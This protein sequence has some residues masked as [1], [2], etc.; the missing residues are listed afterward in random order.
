M[1]MQQE[2]GEEPR[3]RRATRFTRGDDDGTSEE[4]RSRLAE[5]ERERAAMELFAGAAA[6]ELMQPLITAETLARSIEQRLEDRADDA[7]RGDLERLVRAVSRMRLLVETLL[8]DARSHGRPVE[9]RPVSLERL[10]RDSIELLEGEIR[11]RDAR[12]LAADLPVVQGDAVMLAAVV[13][14]LLMNALRYGPRKNGE[15]RIGARRERAQWQ[16]SVTSQGPTL[17]MQD[18]ARIFEPYRRGTHERRVAGA[19][20]GLTICRWFVERHGGAIGVAP[21]GA[22]GNRFHFTIPA[23]TLPTATVSQTAPS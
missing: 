18:R 19:G 21:A 8:L 3:R 11:A 15:V 16:I 9:R 5:S 13:N 12:I 7:T 23:I 14:N 1:E 2:H 22:G 10:V 17:S 20:L 4:Q 6:H